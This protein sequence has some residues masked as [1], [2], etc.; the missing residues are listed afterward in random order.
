MQQFIIRRLLNMLL[1]LLLSSIISFIVVELPPGDYSTV[2]RGQLVGGK[3]RSGADRGPGKADHRA[4]R[5]GQTIAGSVLAL[6]FVHYH[7]QFRLLHGDEPADRRST[8]GTPAT[9]H[10]RQLWPR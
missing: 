5:P 6:A 10:G 1:V 9:D 3:D 2:L 7:V 8:A 4:I